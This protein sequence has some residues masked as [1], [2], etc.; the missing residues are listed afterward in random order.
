MNSAIYLQAG[1]SAWL[2]FTVAV[3]GVAVFLLVVLLRI[4]PLVH[5]PR[6]TGRVK[7][8][9]ST[10]T[11][12]LRVPASPVSTTVSPP[13]I[14]AADRSE[15][16]QARSRWERLVEEAESNEQLTP[17]QRQSFVEEGRRR[18]TEIGKQLEELG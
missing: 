3:C 13:S 5:R 8:F 2:V 6:V 15:L 17:E 10:G 4:L 11:E 12:M 1:S 9:Q 16:L 7:P 18:I 14:P